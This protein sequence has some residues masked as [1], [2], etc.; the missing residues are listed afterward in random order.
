LA[1]YLRTNFDA[2]VIDEKIIT[3]I[4]DLGEVADKYKDSAD[5]IL[6]V[7]TVNWAI[8]YLRSNTNH[9]RVI[10]SSRLELIDVRTKKIIAE[11]PCYKN[12]SARE[13]EN[14]P[15]YDALLYEKAKILKEEL[16]IGA[17]ACSDLFERV[18]FLKK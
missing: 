4:S 1:K 6:N 5:Y 7:K 12:P 9:Y 15:T 18:V 14:P 16:V 17:N 11:S 2:K 3:K 8:I 13:A 10:Y